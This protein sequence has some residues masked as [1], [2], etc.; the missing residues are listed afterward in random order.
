MA[1]ASSRLIPALAEAVRAS[2]MR[3][4]TTARVFTIGPQAGSTDT[5]TRSTGP[6]WSRMNVV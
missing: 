6:G 2:A 1:A 3:A 4:S 5:R